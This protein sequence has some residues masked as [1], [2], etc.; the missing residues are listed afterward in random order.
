MFG[1][2]LYLYFQSAG[3][4]KNFGFEKRALS[5]HKVFVLALG[6]FERFV[7]LCHKLRP[8]LHITCSK[9]VKGAG[10]DERFKR[11]S[12]RGMQINSCNKIF[13]R[14]ENTFFFADC[15]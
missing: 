8:Y 13:P 5:D 14:F 12:V 9:T 10:L 6:K 15:P 7:E 11:L 2:G 4:R 1:P 3:I